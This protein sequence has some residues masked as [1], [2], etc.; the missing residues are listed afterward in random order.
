MPDGRL[1]VVDFG[2]VGAVTPP[3]R[4]ALTTLLLAVVSRDSDALAAAVLSITRVCRPVDRTGLSQQLN[5][6]LEPMIGAELQDLKLGRVLRGL[7]HVLRSQGLM[8]PADL[9][10]LVKTV[11][12]CEA[13]ADELDPT[14]NVSSFLGELGSVG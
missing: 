12:E 9:A 1:G 3:T 4:T 7:L 2:E 13:T 10:V 8:L 6:L 5:A 11:I 14:L